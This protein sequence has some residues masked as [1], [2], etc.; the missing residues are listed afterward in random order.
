VNHP[1]RVTGRTRGG[2]PV[3]ST[4]AIWSGLFLAALGLMTG[5]GGN[6]NRGNVAGTVTV[7]GQPATGAISFMPVDGKAPSTGG[8]IE[9]GRFAVEVPFGT[10][11]VAI[12]VPKV[13]GQRKLYD[14]PNSPV[15]PVMDESLPA[16]YNDATELTIEVKPGD[17]PQNFDLKTK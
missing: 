16:K 4:T 2:D 11:K 14:T 6:P 1:N 3:G 5:C 13:V 7:D 9:A 8:S 10:S 17:N 12:R 15:Q